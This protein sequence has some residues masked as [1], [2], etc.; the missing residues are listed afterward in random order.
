MK[1]T[2]NLKTKLAH[3][4]SISVLMGLRDNLLIKLNEYDNVA[5][6]GYKIALDDIQAVIV[7]LEK[8][9]N[10]ADKRKLNKMK[11]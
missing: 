6:I 11:G 9:L 1:I 7:E 8:P 5:Q 3:S 2:N 10:R 4:I